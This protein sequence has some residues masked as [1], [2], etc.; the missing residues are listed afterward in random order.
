MFADLKSSTE[1]NATDGPR[2]AAVAYT[3]FTRAMA[4][5]LDGF[6]AKYTEIQGDAVFGLFSGRGSIFHAAAC[7]VTMRTLV[8]EEVAVRFGKDTAAD[9][10]LM[11]GIGIDSGTLL[12]RRLGLR[13]TAENEVWAGMPVNAASKLSSL[14]GP[15]QVAVSERVF[16]QYKR[17]S[18][19]RQQVL[20]QGC[21]CRSRAGRGGSSSLWKKMEVPKG[22]GLDF[23]HAYRLESPWCPKH[24]AELCEAL[25]TGRKPS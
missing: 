17:V 25:I 1:L 18:Q 22:L 16:A 24:G 20:L 14:A 13:G 4:L 7:G 3:D 15:N 11:A 23:G 2:D 10:K 21:E 19:L 5:I 9:W 12:V 8:E 6:S